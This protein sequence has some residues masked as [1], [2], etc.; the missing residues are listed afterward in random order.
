VADV[1]FVRRALRESMTR[2]LSR[3]AR[4]LTAEREL[5]SS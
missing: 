1:L 3:F 4:E 5:A 2:T